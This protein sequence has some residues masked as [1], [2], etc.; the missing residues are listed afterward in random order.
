MKQHD[1]HPKIEAFTECY[2]EAATDFFNGDREM[3]K[4]SVLAKRLAMLLTTD[5]QMKALGDL[6]GAIWTLDNRE[7]IERNRSRQK[8]APDCRW[9]SAPERVQ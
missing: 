9:L 8:A 1:D 6:Y 3:P 2:S 7:R 4:P 5:A